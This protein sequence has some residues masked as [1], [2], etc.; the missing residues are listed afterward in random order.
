[1]ASAERGKTWQLDP[2]ALAR[3]LT[4][5]DQDLAEAAHKY[6]RLRD[7]L[8]HL[9]EW[10]QCMFAED[11]ADETIDRVIRRMQSG[12]QLDESGIARYSA[13]VAHNVFL[14]HLREVKRRGT[15]PPT[16]QLEW[17]VSRHSTTEFHLG[18][19]D[20]CLARL[21]ES[22]R[23]LIIRYYCDEPGERI[24]NRRALATELGISA[25]NLRIKA[26][27]IRTQLERWLTAQ[28][29]EQA[30]GGEQS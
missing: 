11:L 25:A 30:D 7:K 16:A 27:R 15:K 12:V 9:F 23:S 29:S 1:M 6:E 24:R 18:L 14:E 21:D 17:I 20:R 19:L 26:Y 22:E 5:L 2:E 28:R 4:T 8:I 10:R 3:F 13:G